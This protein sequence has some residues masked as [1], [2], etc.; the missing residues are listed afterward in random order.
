MTNTSFSDL[1]DINEKLEQLYEDNWQSY[2]LNVRD[3][4]PEPA[5]FPFLISVQ[6]DYIHS[7]KRI[8]ICGQETQGWGNR[9]DNQP[10]NMT[11][12]KILLEYRNFVGPIDGKSGYN[13]PYWNFINAIMSVHTDK[14]FVINNIVKTGRR[15]GSGCNEII[16]ELS[17]KFFPVNRKEFEFLKPDYL[18]FLTGPNYDERIKK[19]LGDFKVKNLND[20]LRCIDLLIFEDKNLPSA[21]RCYHPN[22]IQRIK[23]RDNYLNLIHLYLKDKL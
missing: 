23:K 1:C 17:I 20:E 21:I 16:N 4:G 10:K 19:I 15:Y 9:Y 14:A 6:D 12:E 3:S 13:S 7:D 2:L 11:Y 5:A 22:Y 18:I 8:M